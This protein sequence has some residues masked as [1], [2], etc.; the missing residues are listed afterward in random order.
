M[1]QSPGHVLMKK[2]KR[3]AAA[4]IQAKCANSLHHRSL[5]DLLNILLNPAVAIDDVNTIDWCKWLMAGGRTPDEFSSIVRRYDNATTC[6]LVW[7]ANFVAYRCRTCGISPCMSLCAECFQR[8]DHDGHDFNMFRS[9]AGGA[10][11]CGDTSVMKETGFCDRH[12]PKSQGNKPA[13]PTDLMCVTE[14]VMPRIILRLIQHLRESSKSGAQDAHLVAI[15][16]ADAFLTMLNDLSAMGAAMRRT[17]TSAL[18]NPSIYH[19]LTDIGV[20]TETM[21][22]TEFGKYMIESHKIYEE[23]VN[24]LP[25][26]APLHEHKDIAAL[27]VV[28]VHKTFLE[29]LVFWT[30]KLEFPQKVV[31]LLLNM[32]PDPDY[33][34]SLTQAFVLHY[35][36]ISM[37]L[38]KSSDPDTLSNRVVHVSVQLFSN[39]ALALRMAQ[40]LNLLHVMVISLK[41]MMVKILI[42]S[43]L[44]EADKNFHYVVDCG[45]QVMREHCYWPLVS[46][47]NNVLSHRPVAVKFMSDVAL[48]EMWFSFL[49]FFQGMNVNQRELST[50]VEFEPNTYYAA[51]SAE[52]EASAYPMWALLS[53][54]RKPESVDLTQRVLNAALSA[55]QDWFDAI[56]ITQPNLVSDL[57]SYQV[58]F[59]LPLHRYLAVFMCQAI[60]LQGRTLEEVL[61]SHNMLQLIMIHP[62]RVQVSARL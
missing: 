49:S 6:G 33:K 23:A 24:S 51:F 12:G 39:E 19:Q 62:L 26:P 9:Q 2:G 17:M 14:A 21:A 38:E 16:E 41:Y 30:V 13:A 5:D 11:D 60:N 47:L 52:L 34:E 25:N 4:Y 53:H 54:L 27:K 42:P 45:R 15:Q 40:N 59:H 55:L 31:C 56:Y 58:S 28:L 61:P 8:G 10:C 29:E 48:L 50:H 36:R 57:E 37:M 7:T 46:D 43:T 1:E 3:L 18:T 22:L 35:S 32:L 20:L 44:H